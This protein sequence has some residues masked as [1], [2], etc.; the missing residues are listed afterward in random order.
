MN[1]RVINETILKLKRTGFFSIFISNVF[2][3]VIAF[4]GNIFIVRILSKNNYGIYAYAINAMTMLYIF[5][6]FG[7]SNAALQNLTEANNDKERQKA[8][9]KYA[10][11]VGLIGSLLSGIL[12]LL[13]PL[14]YPFEIVEAK[15]Y[16][17]I[18]CL[19]PLLSNVN[20]FISIVLRANFENRKFAILNFSKTAFSY[21]FLII[22]SLLFGI[23]GAIIS[24]YC[25]TILELILG[26]I[27][28]KS[29]LGKFDNKQKMGRK[30]QKD[31]LKYAFSTQINS[32]LSS[33]LLNIDLFLIGIMIA[34]PEIIATYKVATAI[35]M[36]LSFLPT[37]VMIYVLP[38]FVK[39]NKNY[40]WI[41]RNYKRLISYGAI[42]YGLLTIILCLFSKVIFNLLYGQEYNNA[43]IA[44]N[45][46]MIGF[47]F[48]STIKIPSNN[49]L[50]SM[51]KL[52]I[53]LIV[54]ISS[55]I[56]N[57]LLN[58]IFINLIGMNGAAI[59]TTLIN[60]FSS[61]VLVCYTKRV[62]LK[63]ERDEKNIY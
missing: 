23:I 47:F 40:D 13:S 30:E 2:S 20:A 49:I 26:L 4:L 35:P 33:I 41:K 55:A 32:T 3:K 34:N 37:C 6:D 42:A 48:S 46:L 10:L 1:K 16:V 22:L 15:Y 25:Y 5:N 50:Y 51:R 38:Y 28:A 45:I 58:V 43:I 31:F 29:V 19:I 57:L 27:F 53:N 62:L 8:I 17:P 18:L 56:L 60:V 61:I 59:T 36:A 52:K 21:I 54:T 44:F 24:Q 9:L 14:F 39:N 12:I 63:G 11:K 7:A